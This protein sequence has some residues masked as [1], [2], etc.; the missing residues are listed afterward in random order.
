VERVSLVPGPQDTFELYHLA[1]DPD[2]LRNV[3]DKNP[4][5]LK[6]MKAAINTWSQE[7]KAEKSVPNL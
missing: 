1:E 3:A 4:E 6:A 5:A 2:E 7:I